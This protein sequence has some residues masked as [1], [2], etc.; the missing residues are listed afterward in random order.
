MFDGAGLRIYDKKTK[1]EIYVSGQY[2]EKLYKFIKEITSKKM[3]DKEMKYHIEQES[4]RMGHK[5]KSNFMRTYLEEQG[6][7]GT[8]RNRK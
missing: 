6:T 1:Q 2:W 3:T 4:R 7:G 8:Y 5:S